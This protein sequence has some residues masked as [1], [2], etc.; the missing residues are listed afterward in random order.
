MRHFQVKTFFGQLRPCIKWLT[1]PLQHLQDSLLLCLS[2]H[3]ELGP[4]PSPPPMTLT[5]SFFA[6]LSLIPAVSGMLGAFLRQKRSWWGL[7]FRQWSTLFSL[8]F[9]VSLAS[10]CPHSFW[11]TTP[12]TA[13]CA[14]IFP[15][16]HWNTGHDS[17]QH[18]HNLLS[19]SIFLSFCLLASWLFSNWHVCWEPGAFSN[20]WVLVGQKGEFE[21]DPFSQIGHLSSHWASLL[22]G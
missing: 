7:S 1:S 15:S 2:V 11:E 4:L 13:H 17:I 14:S 20:F 21:R 18:L 6:P 8:A 9:K 3:V 5:N 16:C 19:A 12:E 10:W 22:L